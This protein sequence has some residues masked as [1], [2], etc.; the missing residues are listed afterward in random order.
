MCWLPVPKLYVFYR[1]IDGLI[2]CLLLHRPLTS[3]SRNYKKNIDRSGFTNSCH[4]CGKTFKKPSQLVRHI[5]IH[6]GKQEDV[7]RAPG[8]RNEGMWVAH[9]AGFLGLELAGVAQT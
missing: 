3:S 2:L 7:P 9:A 5:R 8:T 6:T 1:F 4:H